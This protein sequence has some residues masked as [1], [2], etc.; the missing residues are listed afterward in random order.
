M[1]GTA[2]SHHWDIES[3]ITLEVK[4]QLSNL[5]LIRHLVNSISTDLGLSEREAVQMEMA[6]DEACANS[7]VSIQENEGDIPQAKVRLEISVQQHC[8]RV[9]IVDTGKSFH[10]QY[11]KAMPFHEET[12]RT[13]KRGY[14][15]QIIKTFM[16]EVHYIHDPRIGNKLILTK[17]LSA[18]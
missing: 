3:D 4:P 2:M 10:E 1:K 8:L 18:E 9:A 7:I 15:L 6:V 16:D 14:G 13:C 11:E 17:Y 5:S 12:D